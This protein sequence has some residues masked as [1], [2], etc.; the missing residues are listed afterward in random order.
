MLSVI[1]MRGFFKFSNCFA[2][3]AVWTCLSVTNISYAQSTGFIPPTDDEFKSYQLKTPYFGAANGAPPGQ[4]SIARFFPQPG[5]QA[6]QFSCMG[7]AFAHGLITSLEALET[8]SFPEPYSAA[9]LYNSTKKEEPSGVC[10]LGVKP[11]KVIKL[12]KEHGVPH[13]SR[14]PFIPNQCDTI[15][16]NTV[17][18][19][20][21]R[22]K[23]KN[24]ERINGPDV[25]G[26]IV[27]RVRD[28]ISASKQ[29]V[30]IGMPTSSNF[31]SYRSGV[32]PS[33]FQTKDGQDITNDP[34]PNSGYHAMVIVGYDSTR[35]M[36]VM[37]SYGMDWGD[38]GFGWI[39]DD[40]IERS[41]VWL[42]TANLG[43]LTT[44]DTMT[45]ST[46]K[47]SSEATITTETSTTFGTSAI[48]LGVNKASEIA[49]TTGSMDLDISSD[50][51]AVE[52]LARLE[53]DS[54]NQDDL[55]TGLGDPGI[56]GSLNADLMESDFLT[57]QEY[58]RIQSFAEKVARS[59][60]GTVGHNAV[61][62]TPIGHDYYP[63]SLWIQMEDEDLDRI[64][65][66][67]YYWRA[68]SFKNLKLPN[69][70]DRS[71]MIEYYGYGSV[72]QASIRIFLKDG[73]SFDLHYPFR[74]LWDFGSLDE[75]NIDKIIVE[76]NPKLEIGL[77]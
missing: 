51:G 72:P 41:D 5:E 7:F 50:I 58:S 2:S 40:V 47:S 36:R 44:S 12:L 26:D 4:D 27:T 3:M 62:Q 42:W 66:V 49:R 28:S 1:P 9:Y 18:P 22:R 11:D 71:F 53:Q 64:E 19:T 34:I 74:S 32:Y 8:R 55:R 68:E 37:N 60:R 31:G 33:Q 24:I 29:P 77:D 57:P 13:S 23:L 65:K 25:N 6:E 52:R 67:Q 30:V 17:D 48:G 14:K 10:K 15:D 38:L 56:E 46:S 39:D 54:Q 69:S 45:T 70:R 43:E 59:L 73:N 16:I 75:K 63:V 61:G 21:P 20:V 35:G 76:P